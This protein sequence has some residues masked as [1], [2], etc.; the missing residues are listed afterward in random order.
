MS[1]SAER[2][3][4]VAPLIDDAGRSARVEV[5]HALRWFERVSHGRFAAQRIEL[6]PVKAPRELAFY[7]HHRGM[8]R[9]PRNSQ[10]LAA[11]VVA[12]LVARERADGT[13]SAAIGEANFVVCAP[14]VF[15]AHTWRFPSGGAHLGGSRW[16]RRYALLPENAPLGT[17]AHELGHL[18]FGWP[19]FGGS[20]QLGARCLMA[21]GGLN[22]AGREPAPPCA[23]LC[24]REGWRALVELD[25]R[26]P[27]SALGESRV[28]VFEHDQTRWMLELRPAAG[29]T[30]LLVHRTPLRDPLDVR[31][32]AVRELSPQGLGAGALAFVA[33][34][35]RDS[36][37]RRELSLDHPSLRS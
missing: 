26:T 33:E 25:A 20:T 4:V 8:G 14:A 6:E 29:E 5:D 19:D 9:A 22:E 7:A 16:A 37:Q 15:E 1:A 27:L 12:E 36:E 35:L 30:T 31:L 32:E 17:V 23:P 11:D 34:L 21:L 18:L 28:G 24:V 3:I 10:S 2:C 13:G